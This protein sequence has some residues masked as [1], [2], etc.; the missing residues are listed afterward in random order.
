VID[1]GPLSAAATGVRLAVRVT[2]KASRDEVT[3]LA[4]DADDRLWVEARVRALPDKGKANAAITKLIASEIGVAKT[5]V[6]VLSGST[7]RNKILLID[8]DPGVLMPAL[9]EWL[10]GLT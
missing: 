6:S 4:R 10:E 9:S 1:A 8:G 3:G 2:P 7:N 5:A